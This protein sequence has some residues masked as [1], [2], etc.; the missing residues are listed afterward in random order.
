MNDDQLTAA[1]KQAI[2]YTTMA[3]VIKRN[4]SVEDIQD[5]VFF[6]EDRQVVAVETL[7]FEGIRNISL[8]AFPNPAQRYFTLNINAMQTGDASLSIIDNAGR[9]VE[10][11]AINLGKGRNTLQFELPAQLVGGLYTLLLEMDGDTGFVKLMKGS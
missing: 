3:D 9:T 11:H 10:Q 8:E 2:T 1:E 5:N 4:T 7:P 6:A